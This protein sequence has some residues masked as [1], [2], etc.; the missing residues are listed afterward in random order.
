MKFLQNSK[1][2]EKIKTELIFD[3]LQD[4]ALVVKVITYQQ[5]KMFFF[6]MACFR[7]NRIN[8]A[9]LFSSITARSERKTN[10]RRAILQLVSRD[11][12]AEQ[13]Q[14]LIAVVKVIQ[15]AFTSA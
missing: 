2:S 1:L 15:A 6:I 8:F 9:D 14:N 12:P 4:K 5:G 10:E 3:L 7:K 13:I 11:G